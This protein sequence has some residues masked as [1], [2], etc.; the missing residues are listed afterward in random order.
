MEEKSTWMKQIDN[1]ISQERA[2][3]GEI[4]IRNSCDIQE[5]NI[6]KT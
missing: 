5:I 4:F 2:K 3:K 6:S 1:I